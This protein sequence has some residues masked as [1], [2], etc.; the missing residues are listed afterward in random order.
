M[1]VYLINGKVWEIGLGDVSRL[2]VVI[3]WRAVK[4][5]TTGKAFIGNNLKM[6]T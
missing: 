2:S 5:F 4:D 3:L 1:G 6:S